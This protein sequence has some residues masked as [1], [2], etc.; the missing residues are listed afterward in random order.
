MSEEPKI[1]DLTA[2]LRARST[3]GGKDYV[4]KLKPFPE[5]CSLLTPVIGAMRNKGLSF[6]EIAETM[7]FVAEVLDSEK[8]K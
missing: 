2:R 5:I 7:R 6:R 1:V 4:A 3:E 8:T